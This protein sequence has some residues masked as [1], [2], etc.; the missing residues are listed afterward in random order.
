MSRL[1]EIKHER[2]TVDFQHCFKNGPGAEKDFWQ[3][4]RKD[5]VIASSLIF[6]MSQS[7]KLDHSSS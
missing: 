7:D 1:L 5:E 3:V 4:S 2:K 6:I